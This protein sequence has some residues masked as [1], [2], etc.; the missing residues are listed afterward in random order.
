MATGP[1]RVEFPFERW[2]AEDAHALA[3]Y[4]LDEDT[5]RTAIAALLADAPAER[6]LQHP[7]QAG[8]GEGAEHGGEHRPVAGIAQRRAD[9]GGGI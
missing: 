8:D 6:T 9:G 7:R 2:N 4:A 1:A 5:Y 3:T